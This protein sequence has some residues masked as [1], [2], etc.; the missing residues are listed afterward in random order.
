MDFTNTMLP[1]I[2]ADDS[3]MPQQILLPAV[4]REDSGKTYLIG[5]ALCM[6]LQLGVDPAYV[7]HDMCC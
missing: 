5:T 3:L 2:F 6:G 4:R 1:N 7:G